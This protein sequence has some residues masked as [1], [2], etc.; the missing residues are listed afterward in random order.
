MA[1]NGLSPSECDAMYAKIQAFANFGFAESHA[2]SFALLVYAS[3]WLKLHYPAIFTASLLRAQPMGF[4]SPQTLTADARRHGVE[5][6]R[7]HLERSG[8]DAGVEPLDESL[9]L[10]VVLAPSGLDA[11]CAAEQPPVAPFNRFAPDES[12][13]HRRDGQFVIRLGL[14]D[15]AG[16]GRDVAERIIRERERGGAYRDMADLSRRADLDAAQLEALA[17]AGACDHFGMDRRQ[18]LWLAGEVA[19]DSE[20][21]LAGTVVVVQPP[22]LPMLSPSEQ[23]LYDVLAT[24]LSPDD[25]PIRHVRDRLT[26]RGAVSVAALREIDSGTRVW[27]GGAVTHRQRPSTAGGITFLNIEDETGLLNVVASVGVWQRYR[28]VARESAAL[29]VRGL[30]ER[31]EDG[32]VNLVADA[33]EPLTVETVQRSRDFR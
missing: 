25:H 16:I 2:I 33:F 7:P 9:P 6:R 28:R 4:Y 11:C 32:V 8:I 17:A 13:A 3:A 18:A 10:D 20:R 14:T 31:S 12:A 30:L 5:V 24:G 29:V 19:L 23:V 22:L 26:A 27:V 21:I 15:G 1:A